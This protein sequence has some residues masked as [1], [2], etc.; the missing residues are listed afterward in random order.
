MA[1]NIL[2][3]FP[4]QGTR[5]FKLCRTCFAVCKKNVIPTMS[6]SNGYRYPPKPLTLPYL[7]PISER[8]ISPRLPYVQIRRLQR[9]GCYGMINQVINVPVD[10]VQSLPR[11]LDNDFTSN[12]FHVNLKRSLVHKSSHLTRERH[13][14]GLEFR[15]ATY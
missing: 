6:E 14:L 7:D 3:D 10:V 1:L 2:V 13:D 8:L 4:D 5:N 11:N 9:V 15:D 12:F